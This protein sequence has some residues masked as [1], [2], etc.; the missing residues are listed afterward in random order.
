MASCTVLFADIVVMWAGTLLLKS[1]YPSSYAEPE[2]QIEF[3]I[4]LRTL[5]I[6]RT[7]DH[8][9]RSTANAALR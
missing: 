1:R 2:N 7:C 6:C 5:F 9:Y 3:V 8:R 4:D